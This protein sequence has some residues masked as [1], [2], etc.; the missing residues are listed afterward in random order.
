MK[1]KAYATEVLRRK[2]NLTEYS[3]NLNNKFV[4]LL[5]IVMDN[6]F[7]LNWHNFSKCTLCY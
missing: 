6:N 3:N 1:Y 4:N 7:L 2:F 5:V